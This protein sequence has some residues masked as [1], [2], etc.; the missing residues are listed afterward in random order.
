VGAPPGYIYSWY[1]YSRGE[2]IV[3]GVTL[4]E[5]KGQW[6]EEWGQINLM[7]WGWVTGLGSTS[8][9]FGP[10]DTLTH[11]LRTSPGINKIR[12]QYCNQ[13][14]S[15]GETFKGGLVDFKIG[16][17]IYGDDGIVAAG[18]NLTR[19]FVGSFTLTISG[20][21]GGAAMFTATNFTSLH[22][23]LYHLPGVPNHPTGLPF[24]TVKQTFSWSELSPCQ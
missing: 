9:Y 14:A 21:P 23:F 18:S 16:P 10:N 2:A 7:F 5:L 17:G 12:K 1:S 6:L 15:G 4:T 11:R 3:L 22:S 13:V 19:Q 20:Q 24:G 8:R